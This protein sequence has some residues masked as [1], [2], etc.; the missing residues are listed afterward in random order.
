MCM[1][2]QKMK[3]PGEINS[4]G[5][6]WRLNACWQKSGL[7]GRISPKMELWFRAHS[8]NITWMPLPYIISSSYIFGFLKFSWDEH[9]HSVSSLFNGHWVPG[10]KTTF[11]IWVLRRKSKTKTEFKKKKKRFCLCVVLVPLKWC[12]LTLYSVSVEFRDLMAWQN[13]TGDLFAVV[14]CNY[15]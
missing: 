5:P 14:K 1:V 9:L 7:S 11:F 2:S 8:C 15:L 6:A 4:T 10:W 13:E 12:K 3:L